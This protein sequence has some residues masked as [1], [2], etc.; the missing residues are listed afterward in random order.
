MLFEM[1]QPFNKGV[2]C[3]LC[4]ADMEKIL[5]TVLSLAEGIVI[6]MRVLKLVNCQFLEQFYYVYRQLFN[7]SIKHTV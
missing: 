7:A 3:K 1:I 5:K 6:S 4:L 2:L